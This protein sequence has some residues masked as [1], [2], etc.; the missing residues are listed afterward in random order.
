MLTLRSFKEFTIALRR[1]IVTE[2]VE[3]QREVRLRFAG[4]RFDPEFPRLLKK[5]STAAVCS[6][7]IGLVFQVEA[8][9]VE[10]QRIVER[11]M[12]LSGLAV[13]ENLAVI[14]AIQRIERGQGFEC[15]LGDQRPR[16]DAAAG[17]SPW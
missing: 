1:G 16:R 6:A 9:P 17:R 2:A 4:F 13:L 14:F 8:A 15:G 3:R 10:V 5:K 7:A 12:I 11:D